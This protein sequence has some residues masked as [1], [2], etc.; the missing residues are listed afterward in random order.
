MPSYSSENLLE[1]HPDACPTLTDFRPRSNDFGPE[2]HAL[3]TRC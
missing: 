2:T 3:E 1:D